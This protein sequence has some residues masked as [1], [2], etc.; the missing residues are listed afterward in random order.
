M[1]V[2]LY[3]LFPPFELASLPFSICITPWINFLDW[4]MHV[5]SIS[6]NMHLASQFCI[7]LQC[8]WVDSYRKRSSGPTASFFFPADII[9]SKFPQRSQNK[10]ICVLI[11]NLTFFMRTLYNIRK[12]KSTR[13]IML[14]FLHASILEC[15]GYVLK[16]KA[17]ER[18]QEFIHNGLFFGK[19]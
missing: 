10:Y 19:W 12:S 8:F 1:L 16:W 7:R 3:I 9:C 15:R 13:L 2:L 14:D 17:E 4:Y 5:S 11:G 6:L 18:P